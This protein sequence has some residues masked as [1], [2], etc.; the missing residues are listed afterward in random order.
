MESWPSDMMPSWELMR[1]LSDNDFRALQTALQRMNE[2]TLTRTL[3]DTEIT[4][5]VIPVGR[6][7]TVAMAVQVKCRKG[8]VEW[9]QTFESVEQAR[10]AMRC[11]SSRK[12]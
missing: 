5:S 3:G 1:I 4:A 7:W 9:V 8:R 6:A 2:I 10:R 11:I 12:G